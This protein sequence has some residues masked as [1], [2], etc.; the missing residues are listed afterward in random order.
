MDVYEVIKTILLIII[1]IPF[2]F[3]GM[4]LFFKYG[5]LLLDTWNKRFPNYNIDEFIDPTNKKKT[6]SN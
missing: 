2:M 5:I 6:E 4:I 1:L 3:L